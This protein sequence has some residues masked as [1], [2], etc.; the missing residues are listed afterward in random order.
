M[1]RPPRRPGRRPTPPAGARRAGSDR[2]RSS[3][4]VRAAGLGDQRGRRAR[5]RR[6]RARGRSSSSRRSRARRRRRVAER[7]EHRAAAR[8]LRPRRGDDRPPVQDL[9][10]VLREPLGGGRRL[11]PQVGDGAHVDARPLRAR[12]RPR[13][14]GRS[15]SRPRRASPGVTPYSADQPAGAA[16]QHHAGN[17]VAREHE[18]LLDRAGRVDVLRA[19]GSGAACRPARPGRARRSGRAPD[20]ELSTS[21]PAARAR[22]ASSR[23][24]SWPP[25][26]SS[27]PPGSGPSSTSTTS[28]PSSAAAIAAAEA[29]VAAADDEH[30]GVAP[31][32]LGPPRP[33]GLRAS[34]AGRGRPRAG[35]PSRTAATAAAGG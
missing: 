24:A 18:R 3:Y 32:V 9:D 14:L 7:G 35:A 29:G 5:R 28:A 16:R 21:T 23:A 17:V 15:V 19:R 8:P 12:A 33:L 1:C 31:A 20:A 4:A 27:R 6:R 13:S 22:A 10:P 26:H 11:S 25:S 2:A 34:A 30:V